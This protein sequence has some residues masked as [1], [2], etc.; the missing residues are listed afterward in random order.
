MRALYQLSKYPETPISYPL[1]FN[2]WLESIGQ[3]FGSA[4]VGD[5]SGIVETSTIQS[6]VVTVKFDGGEP[7][8]TYSVPVTCTAADGETRT[9]VLEV[10]VISLAPV[11]S[12]PTGAVNVQDSLTG[13]STTTAPSVRAVNAALTGFTGTGNIDG[14]LPDSTYGGSSS[15]DGGGP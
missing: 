2:P 12:T 13:S 11:S 14:G 4:T 8:I 7:G 10:S 9:A 6:G 3:A 15:I 1:D 5:A